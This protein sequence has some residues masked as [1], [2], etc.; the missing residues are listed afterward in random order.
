MESPSVN[1]P[2]TPLPS[3]DNPSAETEMRY[4]K[5]RGDVSLNQSKQ[6]RKWQL[7][8]ELSNSTVRI[9]PFVDVECR[10]DFA[11]LAVVAP[12]EFVALQ[13]SLA[14]V[15]SAGGGGVASLAVED[16]GDTS[17]VAAA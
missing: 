3:A 5:Q 13:A 12:G 7:R 9:Q 17:G 15:L 1:H 4:Q 2:T 10:E 8:R 16:L 6:S 14:V 11:L